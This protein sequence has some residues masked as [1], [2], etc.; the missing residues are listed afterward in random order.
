MWSTNVY[1]AMIGRSEPIFSPVLEAKYFTSKFVPKKTIN[2]VGDL[3]ESLANLKSFAGDVFA[4]K[5]E[6]EDDCVL[7]LLKLFCLF[8]GDAPS[9]V[10]ERF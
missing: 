10:S 3:G 6:G 8:L 4:G 9:F 2:F 1:E 5:L 7:A